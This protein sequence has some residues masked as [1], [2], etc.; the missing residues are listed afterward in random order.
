MTSKVGVNVKDILYNR[1]VSI[2]DPLHIVCRRYST[3]DKIPSASVIITDTE[4]LI[5]RSNVHL[6]LY[7]GTSPE[8]GIHAGFRHFIFYRDDITDNEI[9]PHLYIW[10]Q[11]RSMRSAFLPAACRTI[12]DPYKYENDLFLFDFMNGWIT[13]KAAGKEL[14]VTHGELIFLYTRLVEHDRM[15]SRSVGVELRKKFGEGLLSGVRRIEKN[16]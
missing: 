2:T 10:D 13:E 4:D 14:Y 3:G 1:I 6:V 8:E 9:L 16:D 5:P 11:A 15:Y 7:P 12:T